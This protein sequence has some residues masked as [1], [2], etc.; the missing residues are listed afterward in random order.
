M[1]IKVRTSPEP[2]DHLDGDI[3]SVMA[4]AEES[5][6]TLDFTGRRSPSPLSGQRSPATYTEEQIR[7]RSPLTSPTK[8]GFA[9]SYG[10]LETSRTDS[11]EEAYIGTPVDYYTPSGGS[12]GAYESGEMSP[13]TAYTP[14]TRTLLE[15]RQMMGLAAQE[16]DVSEDPLAKLGYKPL[17]APDTP[18]SPFNFNIARVQAQ[19]GI[20]RRDSNAEK[21]PLTESTG[22]WLALY[23]T[24]NLGLTLYNKVVLVNFPFPYVSDVKVNGRRTLIFPDS[25]GIAC[26]ERMCGV[27]HCIGKGGLCEWAMEYIWRILTPSKTPARL[28][29]KENLVMAAFSVLYTINIAVSNLSLQLVT[30][31]VCH[32]Y[33]QRATANTPHSSIKWSEHRH[34]SSPS[35]SRASFS[36]AN[37]PC[38]SLSVCY[39]LLQVSDL[40]ESVREIA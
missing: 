5:V 27:L 36:R 15:K 9:T 2:A 30:V 35:S 34:P 19:A 23:F 13:Q 39:R 4:P 3:P 18:G 17:T 16:E 31:P 20:N 7:S 38:S 25:D 1:P 26:A 21:V 28:T 32:S 8:N 29:S 40:R 12:S 10:Q 37:S 14:L 24:F 6:S 11:T 33:H 22:Y